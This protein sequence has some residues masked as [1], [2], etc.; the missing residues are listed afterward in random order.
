MRTITVELDEDVVR[1]AEEIA[2]RTGMSLPALLARFVDG[3]VSADR[4]DEEDY[5]PTLRRLLGILPPSADE[6]DYHRHIEE[7]Y[8]P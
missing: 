2:A 5:P 1:R 7:R 8:G 4:D 3:F 6:S